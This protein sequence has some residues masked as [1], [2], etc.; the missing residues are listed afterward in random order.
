MAQPYRM[1]PQM[2]VRGGLMTVMFVTLAPGLLAQSSDRVHMEA[3]A[4]RAT[5]R[6]RTLQQEA[7]ALASQERTLLG[8]LRKLEIDKQLKAEE[9]RQISAESSQVVAELA[10]NAQRTSDLERQESSGRPELRSRL[11]DIYKMGQGRYLRMLLS[12]TDIRQVGHAARTLSVLAKLDHDRVVSRQRTL[13]EL[14]LTGQTLEDRRRRL[15]GLRAQAQNAGTAL[16]QAAKA[17]NDLVHDIDSRRDLNAQ[18]VG[19]LQ[20]ANQKLQLTLRDLSASPAESALPIRPFR[21]DLEW[22]V[23]STGVR[24]SSRSASSPLS[25]GIDINAAEGAPVTAVHDGVVAFADTFGGFGNLVIIDH[26]AQ[27]FSLYGNLLEMSVT[28]G[29]R[30]E[31]GGTVGTVGPAPAGPP[32]L[33]FELRIDGQSVDPLQWLRKR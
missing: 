17:R 8:D 28:K 14:K 32:E 16:A 9:L 22:P 19:E 13:D 4:R 7:D 10:A 1:P 15:E 6:L 27:S 3:L 31:R 12:T 21:G 20:A 29:G 18:L 26:G 25:A 2:V 30:V 23:A 24:R 5:E 11:I 33:H